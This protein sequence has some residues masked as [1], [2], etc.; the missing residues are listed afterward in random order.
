VVIVGAGRVGLALQRRSIEASI[1]CAL[2]RRDGG[3][4]IFAQPVSVGPIVLAVRNDD[5][6][7]VVPRIP[8][9]R[10]DDL[11]FVQNGMVRDWLGEHSLQG[12][13]RGLL[14][15]AVP[16][17]GAPI[18]DG[19][20]SVFT[21]PHAATLAAWFG[22]MGLPARELD[23]ARFTAVELEKLVWNSAFG[24]LCQRYKVD[25]GT[26]CDH[27]ADEL[28]ALVDELRVL[29]RKTMSVDIPLDVLYDKLV[30]YSRTIPR[31]QGA[32][33]EWPWRNGWFELAAERHG[34]DAPVHRRLLDET[35]ARPT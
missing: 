29:G 34:Y 8:A 21:G 5:L 32:V 14:F 17:R 13:T 20:P 24:L 30:A 12:A 27:H 28:R 22:R 35:G 18:E 25:V 15:F 26:V 6:A 1:D 23:W 11:V 9:H 16:S 10:R 33:K 19:P 31:Y 2:V 7:A 4:E 3:W